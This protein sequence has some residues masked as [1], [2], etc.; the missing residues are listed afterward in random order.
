MKNSR[1]RPR[2]PDRHTFLILVTLL[3]AAATASAEETLRLPVVKDN[4]IVL[5]PGEWHLNAGGR[6]RIRI[7]GNQHLVAMAFDLAP[8]RG[9]RVTGATLICARA[10]QVIDGVTVSTIG[11]D[12]DEGKSNALTSGVGNV[13][14]WGWPGALFPAVTGGNA[15]SLTSSVPSGLADGS[16]HFR[17]DPD[18][19]NALSIGAAFG[20]TIH[21]WNHDTS[22]NPTIWSREAKG[23]E[24]YLLVTVG[25]K[26]PKPEPPEILSLSGGPE[27]FRLRIRGPKTG[28]AY[29]V[30]VDG[31]PL[32]R[33]NI[34]FVLA[35]EEQVVMIRDVP[36][37][38]GKKVRVEIATLSRTGARSKTV[39]AR[40]AVGMPTTLV[41]PALLSRPSVEAEG[42]RDLFVIP[43]TDKY[44]LEG[45]PVGDLPEGHRLVNEIFDGETITLVAARG[46]V[47][48][49]TAILRGTGTVSVKLSLPGL[50]TELRR[51]VYVMAGGRRIPDPLVPLGEIELSPDRD[52]AVCADVLVPFDAKKT[53][54]TGKLTVSD[55]RVIPVKVT[56]RP[57][58][59]PRK[60]SFLCEMNS[61]G[62]PGTV[63]EY[64]R[65]QE[66][67]YDHR[68]HLNILHYS[69][70]TAA[71]GARKCNLDMRLRNGRRMDEQR[72]NRIEPGDRRAFWD[73]FAAAFGPLLTGGHF[74][75]GHRGPIPLPGFYLTFH[76][77]WP[78]NVRRFFDGNPD[79]YEAFRTTPEYAETFEAVLRDFLARARKEGWSDAGF[80]IY[81]NN[82]GALKDA[83]RAPW[84]LD[85]P[86]GYHD[87]RALAFYADLVR[88]AA[89]EG[90]P[91]R[92]RVDI[93]RP[94]FD[95]G[96]L[97]GK[98]DL[99]VVGT[100]AFRRYPRL[101]ADRRELTGEDMWVYGTSNA[102]ETSNRTIM[103]WVLEAFRGGASGVVPWQTVDKKGQALEKGDPLGLFIF[104]PKSGEIHHSLR[105]KAYRRAEQDVEYLLLLSDK[106]GL[107]D[108]AI[109]A[110]I[111]RFV[112]LAG[113]V[114]SS[115]P[116]DAGTARFKS[117]SPEG[118]HRL[119]E[120]TSRLLGE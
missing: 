66:I 62:V 91:V 100:S 82:K 38:A 86:A 88:R 114:D 103:A 74:K 107:E 3:L 49:F 54:Y 68:V 14:G 13:A 110:L 37:R 36:L 6:E 33:F 79:A 111:D 32:P 39:L 113:S 23:K 63:A 28:L 24:P 115:S 52:A 5:Y 22:R 94:Q 120:M 26:A 117:L 71:P 65:L 18:L 108:A 119:R 95:R 4:S 90:S 105:L 25:G 35:G 12:W 55:G 16:Y 30:E 78:L 92:Y 20:L 21:E 102:V 89:G 80:Q 109:R 43:L 59:L 9:K 93:S 97:L 47:T 53:G 31:K 61:Y 48:G 41:L 64:E 77:S 99:W 50:T 70:R 60:A 11:A 45:K 116:E 2:P 46:E 44:D 58:A 57:F 96:E 106:L 76:E 83:A 15:F 118:F 8:I 85:E 98:A 101:L 56:V 42:E 69:H 19:V 29:A 73:D 1:G 17:I 81:L 67:A 84:I 40:E 104:D 7:K 10:D 51:A 112:P 87:Y 27:S 34:P 75:G 72:Y